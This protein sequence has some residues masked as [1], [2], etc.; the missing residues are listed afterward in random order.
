MATTTRPRATAD[1]SIR[2][3]ERLL[4][5]LDQAAADLERGADAMALLAESIQRKLARRLQAAGLDEARLRGLLPSTAEQAAKSVTAPLKDAAELT[6]T[7]ARALKTSGR[8]YNTNIKEPI[9]AAKNAHQEWE[10]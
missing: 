6:H 4:D 7:A 9:N 10:V 3:G 1:T 5:F 8:R 2:S